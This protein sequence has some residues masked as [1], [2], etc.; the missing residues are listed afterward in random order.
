MCFFLLTHT[1]SSTQWTDFCVLY[2]VF[3]RKCYQKRL[4]SLLINPCCVYR[5]NLFFE[6]FLGFVLYDDQ[7]PK[8][9][10]N[11]N[12]PNNKTENEIKK[13]KIK[14]KNYKKKTKRKNRWMFLSFKN[15]II[16]NPNIKKSFVGSGKME[17]IIILKMKKKTFLN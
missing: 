13:K 7:S 14:L 11:N 9:Q 3:S 4:T 16:Q 2:F 10:T 12:K 17:F 15:L 6:S 1:T 8:N 5:L